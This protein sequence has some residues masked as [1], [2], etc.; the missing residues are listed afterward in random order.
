[1]TD[2]LGR[3]AARP[4]RPEPPTV[5]AGEQTER[6]PLDWF[7]AALLAGAG[8]IHLAMAPTHVGL[9]TAEGVGFLAAGW[10]QLALAA[11]V[12]VRP[13][14]PVLLAVAG[15]SAAFLAVWVVSRTVGLPIGSHAGEAESVALVDGATA[16]LEVAALLV[17]VALLS[18]TTRRV[19]RLAWPAAV[20]VVGALVLTTAA[21][22]SPSARD[23]AAGGHDES[24]GGA[25]HGHDGEAGGA[26]DGGFAALQNGQMG[27]EHAE[28]GAAAAEALDPATAGDLAAQLAAT[29]PLVERFPTVADAKAA[30]YW[31]A[32]PF[33]PGLGTHYNS[34]AYNMSNTDGVMDAADI[35]DPIL[36]YDGIE[37][38]SPLAGFMYMAFQETEP[39]GFA[40]SLD[41]WH[42]HTAV[43]IVNTPEGIRTPF[44]ADLNGVTDEMCAAEG[45]SMLDFT[46]YMVHVWTVPGYE[47]ELG[48]FS[49]LN[50][51]ITCP[52]GSYRTIPTKEIG[53]K[54][55]TCTKP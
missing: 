25:A 16:A 31:Q 8:A 41:R 22:A 42:F 21:I 30:G 32:G 17:A 38:D 15:T 29:A 1:M 10:V 54:T 20:G 27:H 34:P 39:E 51:R 19:G 6:R 7:V 45:G 36:I 3:S 13:S 43:C 9:D 2:L 40:G 53:D 55:S 24:A 5:T 37:D 11:A 28:E 44:G 50:P 26:D 18:G 23:H 33:S 49:D 52:D 14:K 47:S 46:G 12:L 4:E 35:A 48:T